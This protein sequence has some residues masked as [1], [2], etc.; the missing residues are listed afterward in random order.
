MQSATFIDS[1]KVMPKGQVTIPKDIRKIL[2]I[3]SGDHV[4]FLV[5][6]GSVRMFN[7][8]VYAME[9]LQTQMQGQA[10]KLNMTEDSIADL[11]SQTRKKNK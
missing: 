8:A 11:V 2:G 4:T 3:D 5:E 7:S 9:M 10:T 1:A 6:N